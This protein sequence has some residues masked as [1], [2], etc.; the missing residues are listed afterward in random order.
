MILLSLFFLNKYHIILIIKKDLN[1]YSPKTL[2]LQGTADQE[3]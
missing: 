1:N 3:G 2:K